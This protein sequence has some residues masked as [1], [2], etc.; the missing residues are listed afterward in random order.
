MLTILPLIST[1]FIVISAILVAYGWALIKQGKR[2][3]HKKTMLA[4]SGF[5]LAFFIIYMSRTIFVG[6]MNFG[7]PAEWK[8][9]YQIFLIVHI[10]LA[11]TGAV[12][13]LRMLYTG[14][15]AQWKQHKKIGPGTSIIWFLTAITGVIVYLLLFVIYPGGETN[16]LFKTIL[17]F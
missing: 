5:A 16:S 7:G 9:Y 6:N 4:A 11:T 1:T 2:E 12:L 14:Y 3:E 15:K 13:G 17:G 8:L 10:T